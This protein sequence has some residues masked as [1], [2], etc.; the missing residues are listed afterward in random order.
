V[1]NLT[2]ILILFV[3]LSSCSD[4]TV[5]NNDQFQNT[6]VSKA[7]S[8]VI[9]SLTEYCYHTA[10]GL[11][12]NLP[13]QGMAFFL[14]YNSKVFLFSALHNFTGIDPETGILLKGLPASPNDIWVWQSYY[15]RADWYKKYTLNNGHNSFIVEGRKDEGSKS[16]DI[17]ACN[18]NDS[19]SSPNHIL[20]YNKISIS[21]DILVGD[22]IFY[23]S[24]PLIGNQQSV[25]PRMFVGKIT[26]TSSHDNPYIASDVFSRPGSS[27]APVFKIS[28]HKVSLIGVIARGNSD[29]NIVFITPL[30]ESFLL[31]KL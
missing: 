2:F 19:L 29:K 14:R 17:G 16:Y 11:P 13:V 30:K 31:S 15:D 26:E 9:D 25:I 8:I 4:E 20:D 18:I 12:G 24:Y 21:K 23:S 7:D 3:I 5:E 27:G 28:G 6:A 1:R 10:Y 22:T